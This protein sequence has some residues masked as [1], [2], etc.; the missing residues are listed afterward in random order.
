MSRLEEGVS[1]GDRGAGAA[2]WVVR[3]SLGNT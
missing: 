2:P 1:A 3:A